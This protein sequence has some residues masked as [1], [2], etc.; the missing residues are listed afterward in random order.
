MFQKS[1][2][3]KTKSILLLIIFVMLKMGIGHAASHAFSDHDIA[4]CNECFLILNSNEKNSF[5][6]DTCTYEETTSFIA[7]F[8]KPIILLYKNPRITVY[9]LHQFFNKPPPS[10]A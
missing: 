7:S 9:H 2:I 5:D 6:Y 3:L 4:D 8:H 10:L 1:N